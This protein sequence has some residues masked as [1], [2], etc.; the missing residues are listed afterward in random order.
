MEIILTVMIGATM[1]MTITAPMEI[2]KFACRNMFAESSSFSNHL[3]NATSIASYGR[4]VWVL[5]SVFC[6]FAWIW[7]F[8]WISYVEIGGLTT[9]IEFVAWDEGK[10]TQI[11]AHKLYLLLNR[12]LTNVLNSKKLSDLLKGLSHLEKYSLFFKFHETYAI[13]RVYWG[14]L[15]QSSLAIYKR[16]IKTAQFNTLVNW[17]FFFTYQVQ[18]QRNKSHRSSRFRYET[19]QPTQLFIA[20]LNSTPNSNPSKKSQ[21]K[22]PKIVHFWNGIQLIPSVVFSMNKDVNPMNTSNM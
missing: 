7:F 14:F 16:V 21:K 4:F 22:I 9:S 13:H 5:F 18:K 17:F 10:I 11:F 8:V 2:T 20:I 6:L 19:L 1:T 15:S 3:Y 12:T